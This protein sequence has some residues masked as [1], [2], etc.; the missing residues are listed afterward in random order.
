M[1]RGGGV[2]PGKVIELINEEVSRLG[3]NATAR[4]IGIPLRTVQKYMAGT[5]EPSQ[6][7]LEKIAVHFGKSVAWLRG[8]SVLERILEGLMMK[9]I[10]ADSFNKSVV[11]ETGKEW[12]YWGDLVAGN[13]VLDSV[14]IRY[15]C[16][17][18]D[19]NVH[20]VET[21]G[22]PGL[23]SPGIVGLVRRD[24]I[25][26]FVPPQFLVEMTEKYRAVEEITNR[27][28]ADPELLKKVQELMKDQS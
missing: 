17:L 26:T 10:N 7:T 3:Q 24:D 22:E 9:G 1:G 12:D 2:T 19:I 16:E 15:V 27:L 4:A 5:A 6:A 20:W 11:E 8:G 25:G 21:G 23:L 18:F 13:A 14:T 28:R